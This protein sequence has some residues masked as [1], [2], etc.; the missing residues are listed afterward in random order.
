MPMPSSRNWLLIFGGCVVLGIVVFFIFYGFTSESSSSNGEVGKSRE[1][2]CGNEGAWSSSWMTSVRT[3]LSRWGGDTTSMDTECDCAC[4]EED[5]DKS[6]MEEDTDSKKKDVGTK[7]EIAQMILKDATK[8]IKK[9]WKQGHDEDEDEDDDEDEDQ[10]DTDEAATAEPEAAAQPTLV[11]CKMTPW[12]EWDKCSKRCGVGAKKRYRSVPVAAANGGRAC[13]PLVD[14]D[15]CN[16]G[17]CPVDCKMTSWSEWGECSKRCGGGTKKRYR[18]VSVA[19]ANGGSA[20]GSLEDTAACN[21]DACPESTE[22]E[23][24]PDAAN[25]PATTATSTTTTVETTAA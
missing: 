6:K 21:T 1:R 22:E 18:S 20:C 2:E 19:A 15:V 4:E 12:S 17:A 9:A 3:R 10:G 8:N 14:T 25:A 23:A 11:D 24:T 5:D 13:G 16:I 7:T